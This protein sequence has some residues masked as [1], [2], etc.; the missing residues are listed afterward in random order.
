MSSDTQLIIQVEGLEQDGG[1]VRLDYLLDELASF[2]QVLRVSEQSLVKGDANLVYRVVD[3]KHDSPLSVT[4][5]ATSN[6]QAYI[7]WEPYVLDNVFDILSGNINQTIEQNDEVQIRKA[8][9]RMIQDNQGKFSSVEIERK[10]NRVPIIDSIQLIDSIQ[11]ETE[12]VVS[13][14]IS[15]WGTVKGRV[16]RYNNHG[17]S[18]FFWLYT[19]L[20]KTVKCRFPKNLVEDSALSV[21]KNVSV[22][23][24]L[25][26]RANEPTPFECK[27]EKIDFHKPDDQLPKLEIGKFPDITESEST[28]QVIQRIRDGWE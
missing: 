7:G 22:T 2:L 3:V 21:E 14:N 11:I 18:N 12:K 28:S 25:T 17:G 9:E 16:E 26:Y 10:G 19:A 4:I 24:I 27:V 5:E 8:I 1:E 20:G 23:G 13:K 15:S 6:N